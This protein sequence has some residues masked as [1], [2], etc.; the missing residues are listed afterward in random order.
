MDKD[1]PTSGQLERDI[2]QKIQKLYRQQLEHSPQKVICQLFD[3]KLAIVIEDAL[4]EVEKKLAKINENNDTAQKLNAVINQSIKSKLEILV[5]EIL[6]V[7][8]EDILFDSTFK[9]NQTGAIITLNRP[10]VVRNPSSIPKNKRIVREKSKHPNKVN[11]SK[12]GRD[13]NQNS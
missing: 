11:S 5:E 1:L 9:S 2:S 7:E 3:N 10:P 12:I 6:N 8:V 4:T 13:R